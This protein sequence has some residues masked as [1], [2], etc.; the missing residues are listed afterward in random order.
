MGSSGSRPLQPRQRNPASLGHRQRRRCA[1]HLR[2]IRR[3]AARHLRS[4]VRL[5][6]APAMP[7]LNGQPIP[8]RTHHRTSRRPPRH[9]RRRYRRGRQ[10]VKSD[11]QRNQHRERR[12]T[13][14][15]QP[16]RD[17]L[18]DQLH[19]H[20]GRPPECRHPDHRLRISTLPARRSCL[21][22][23]NTRTT[24]RPNPPHAPST[25]P[26]AHIRVAEK[27]GRAVESKPCDRI[28]HCTKPARNKSRHAWVEPFL[29]RNARTCPHHYTTTAPDFA[30]TPRSA[31]P[32]HLRCGKH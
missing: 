10:R 28:S 16:H 1:G 23:A 27:R 20:L 3:Q 14:A 5:H 30:G 7:A 21:R 12:S 25:R 32:A 18:R 15:H 2:L 19:G 4:D 22:L 8:I 26:M 31:L 6:D 24:G 17:A 11:L 29:A 9:L 13:R